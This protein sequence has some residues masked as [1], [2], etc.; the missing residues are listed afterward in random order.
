MEPSV[1]LSWGIGTVVMRLGPFRMGAIFSIT[2]ANAAQ[3]V[4]VKVVAIVLTKQ[5]M[6]LH[7]VVSV[8]STSNRSFFELLLCR[9]AEMQVLLEFDVEIAA[10]LVS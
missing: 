2:A 6:M 3:V 4:V 9:P 1:G 10:R 5:T 8:T 7:V